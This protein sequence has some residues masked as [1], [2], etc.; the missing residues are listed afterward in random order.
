MF[1]PSRVI[2]WFES[3]QKSAEQQASVAQEAMRDLREELVATR[4]ERD[5]LKTELL[6]AKINF[7]WLRIKVNTLELENK[8][9]MEKAYS[10]KLPVPEIMREEKVHNPFNTFSPFEDMGDDMAA[11]LGLPTYGK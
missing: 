5:I 6:S 4:T 11:K 8:G 2:G 10:I 3:F 7:D 1:I 9:L